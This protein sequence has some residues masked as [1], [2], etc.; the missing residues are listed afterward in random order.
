[1]IITKM[2]IPRRTV[3]RGMAASLALPLL[4]AMIP[5]ASA[6]RDA[7]RPIY[8]FGACYVPCG[9]AMAYWTP[10]SDGKV[11]TLGWASTPSGPLEIAPIL[12]PLAKHRDQMLLVSGLDSVGGSPHAY[13]STAWLSSALPTKSEYVLQA[14]MTA[15]Q[16]I[17]QQFANQ[18]QLA[19]LELAIDQRDVSGTCDV[20][21]ACSYTNTISWRTPTTPL[22]METDPRAVFERLFGDS[23]STDPKVRRARSG[24][25]RSVLD[26]LKSSLRALE[27]DLGPGDR[28]R[29]DEYTESVRDVERRVQRSEEQAGRDL[30]QIEQPAGVPASYEEHVKLMF[31]L[32]L[33]AFQTDLTR[34]STCMLARELTGRTYPEIGITGGHHPI[35]HHVNERNN[36]AALLKINLWQ[37]T[38]FSYLVDK[39]KNTPDGDGTLLDHVALM[40]GAGMSDSNQHSPRNIPLVLVGGGWRERMGRH[41]VFEPGTPNANLLLTAVNKFSEVP[42]EKF[43]SSTGSASL[44]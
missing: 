37:I 25:Q 44:S 18:T 43:G 21:Y 36:Y 3:L 34:V 2:A 11:G 19:S 26:E 30:P 24:E 13:A 5:A 20:G 12:E 16:A 1:M 22:P 27:R 28:A 42:Q 41:I 17:A 4:D 40:Y 23:G 7:A 31:D 29:L 38:L 35:S 8:R 15:D 33:L 6:M 10:K 39:M 14:A 32:Q 9:M